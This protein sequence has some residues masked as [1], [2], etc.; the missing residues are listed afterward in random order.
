M[1][2]ISFSVIL[3]AGGTGTR[4]G[5]EQPKQYLILND[6]PLICHSLE[7]F[8]SMPEVTEIVIVCHPQFKHLF[9][10]YHKDRKILFALPGE[11]RQDSVYNGL[12][13]LQG[14]PL[15]CV[16]DGARPF[17][18]V[19]HIREVVAAASKNNG[20]AILGVP[21]K[22]TIKKC[23]EM[24]QVEKTLDRNVLWEIQTP[25]VA[26]LELL[27]EGFAVANSQNLTV[28]DDASLIEL[29]HKPV[30]VVKGAYENIKMTTP[31]DLLLAKVIME[32]A[33]TITK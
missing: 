20:A 22:A 16:H 19:Y 30:T 11:R 21:V 28:T 29:L 7:T 8:L 9:D 6:K 4:M 25:Q 26:R 15:V 18:E 17:I 5:S 2:F 27:K 23:N 13:Q 31:D 1:S 24:H 32:K 14:N 12:K 33:C 10:S 3:L